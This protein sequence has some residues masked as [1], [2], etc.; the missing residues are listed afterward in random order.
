[1]NMLEDLNYR[2]IEAKKR[3]DKLTVSAFVLLKAE[4]QTNEKQ[5]KPNPEMDV[6]KSYAKKLQKSLVAFEGSDQYKD[7]K[8]ELELVKTLLPEELSEESIQEAVSQYIA[9]HP[10]ETHVGKVIGALKVQLPNAD[11]S[12]LAKIVKSTLTSNN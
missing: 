4:Q 5:K 8:L 10:N 12:I 3:G 11:G 2:I 7:L 6:V 1:M 9:S